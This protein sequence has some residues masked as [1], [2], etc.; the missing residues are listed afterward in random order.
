MK[1]G[2]ND[3]PSRSTITKHRFLKHMLNCASLRPYCPASRG[4]AHWEWPLSRPRRREA[5][6][7]CKYG[8]NPEKGHQSRQTRERHSGF[9]VQGR[10]CFCK[11][12]KNQVF[13]RCES[14]G[15]KRS[16]W[17]GGGRR[18]PCEWAISALAPLD[19]TKGQQG[20]ESQLPQ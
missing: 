1:T 2:I 9:K 17:R 13:P 19:M 8:G 15:L 5:W 14:S 10:P 11:Q 3:S 6:L 12:L 16:G 7:P 4:W 18:G 20:F